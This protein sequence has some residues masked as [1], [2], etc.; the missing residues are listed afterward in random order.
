MADGLSDKEIAGC[1][2]ISRHTVK[3]HLLLGKKYCGIS[4]MNRVQSAAWVQSQKGSG[5]QKG[6]GGLMKLI[7]LGNTYLFQCN[8]GYITEA[9][10]TLERAGRDADMHLSGSHRELMF[11]PCS[12]P[13]IA[14]SR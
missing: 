9:R 12:V 7:V 8:C 1:M 2:E 6:T 13:K 4:R 5:F 11:S 10:F 14:G 3:V